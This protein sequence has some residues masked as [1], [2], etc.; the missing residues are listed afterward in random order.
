MSQTSNQKKTLLRTFIDS[1][2]W[3]SK[4]LD[5]LLPEVYR[6]D[7][8]S[9]FINNV[10]PKYVQHPTL[11][12]YDLGGGSQPFVSLE[13][14][15]K[16]GHT[17]VG[18]DIDADELDAAPDGIYDEKI[19][20]D[21]SQYKGTGDADLVICQAALEHV[22]DNVG[23]FRAIASVLKPGGKAVLFAPSRNAVFARLNLILPE[24]WKRKFLFKLF[25]HKAEGHDGFPAFYDHCT[26]SEFR[27]LASRNGLN[28]EVMRPYYISSYFQIFFPVYALWRL[29]VIVFKT[30]AGEAAAETM[31]FVLKKKD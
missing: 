8:N 22:H 11:K 28:V 6:T 12:I 29:W 3:L 1:Q 20:A 25:P 5:T 16:Y 17:I 19:V 30:V 2:I 15:E 14:K 26:P 18:L 27:K 31:V 24:A 7:G 23:A 10:A 13:Q 21:L 9:D 4:K